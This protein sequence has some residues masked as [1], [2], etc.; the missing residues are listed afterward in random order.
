M[1]GGEPQVPTPPPA[2][3]R[4]PA[5]PRRR[6]AF[7]PNPAPTAPPKDENGPWVGH[8]ASAVLVAL[9]WIGVPPFWGPAAMVWSKPTAI[10]RDF[11]TGRLYY[12]ACQGGP[13]GD[14]VVIHGDRCGTVNGV[15]RICTEPC[16]L[17]LQARGLCP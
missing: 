14:A 11:T 15:P 9:V 7:S 3:P 2:A 17:A 16:V 13:G 6:G 5:P 8:V 12:E 10:V 4:E 1:S